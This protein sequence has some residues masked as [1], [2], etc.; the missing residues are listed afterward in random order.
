[1]HYVPP[2]AENSYAAAKRDHVPTEVLH[3]VPQSGE[4]DPPGGVDE[5][6]IAEDDR[7]RGF[8]V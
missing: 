5:Q 4:E 8:V 2:E 1:M 6:D 3:V 7:Q